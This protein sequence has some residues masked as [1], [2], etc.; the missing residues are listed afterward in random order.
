[1]Q[2]SQPALR[3]PLVLADITWRRRNRHP[4]SRYISLLQGFNMPAA[5]KNRLSS[6]QP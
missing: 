6:H 3:S 1:M 4:Y 2:T 5:R